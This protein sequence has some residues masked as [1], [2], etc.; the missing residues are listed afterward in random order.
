MRVK[1]L[2][3]SEVDGVDHLVRLTADFLEHPDVERLSPGAPDTRRKLETVWGLT[4]AYL[5]RNPTRLAPSAAL[6]G[7]LSHA[8]QEAADAL[9]F[10]PVARLNLAVSPT[11]VA[12]TLREVV[13]RMKT[14]RTMP[15]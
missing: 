5:Q 12:A 8:T 4:K 2:T 10:P 9:S 3:P 15:D 1:L 14:F 13:R 7:K 6:A 11:I